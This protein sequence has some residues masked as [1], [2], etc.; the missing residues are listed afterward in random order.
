MEN[1][2]ISSSTKSAL[3][4]NALFRK[5]YLWMSFALLITALSAL[6]VV[7][8]PALQSFV[9]SNSFAMWGLIIAEFV[10]VMALVARINR[11]SLSTAAFM[12]I[13]YSILNGLTLSVIFFVYDIS[14]IA[15]TFFVTAGTFGAISIYGFITRT[16]LSKFGNILLM[17]LFGIIIA[18]VV[19]M[20][21][22][23]DMLSMV[24]SYVGVVVFVGLTAW[25]TQKLKNLYLEAEEMDESAF[26]IALLGA[27]TLYLD[28]VNLFLY[29]LR[30]FGNR[31]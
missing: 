1:N 8:S 16:D 14:T 9:F 28:F 4:V 12:F 20:F 30:I 19:N 7:K 23:S 31:E 26:K 2:F 6:L 29:L 22:G 5:T 21:V 3:Y 25:D 13:L 10:L 17:A 15:Q 27:L 11:L 18:T 24:I